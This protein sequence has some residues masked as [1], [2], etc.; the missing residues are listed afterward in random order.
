[1]KHMNKIIP[2]KTTILSLQ[3]SLVYESDNSKTPE[4]NYSK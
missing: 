1:M 3:D 4:H 2:K